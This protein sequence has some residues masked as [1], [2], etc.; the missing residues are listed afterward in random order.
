MNHYVC[1]GSFVGLVIYLDIRP[2]MVGVAGRIVSPYSL[3]GSRGL[4]DEINAVIVDACNKIYETHYDLEEVD[5]SL[6]REVI[7]QACS[8]INCIVRNYLEDGRAS[9]CEVPPYEMTEFRDF[10]ESM[11]HREYGDDW[12]VRLCTPLRQMPT[13]NLEL[14]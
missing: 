1:H 11:S 14:H 9:F 2:D 3:L 13:H 8:E 5:L 7:A 10:V 12:C 4:D 6:H